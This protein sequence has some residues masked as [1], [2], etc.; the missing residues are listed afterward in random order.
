MELQAPYRPVSILQVRIPLSPSGL[1]RSRRLH[2]LLQ[3]IRLHEHNRRIELKVLVLLLRKSVT[4]ILRFEIPKWSSV[5]L[6]L[7]GHL[8]RL[9]HRHSRIVRPGHHKRRLSNL[10]SVVHRRNAFHELTHLRIALVAILHA[11]QIA[12]IWLRMFEQRDQIAWTNYRQLAAELVFIE[13]SDRPGH[14]TAVAAACDHNVAAIEFRT[15]LDP[16]DQRS[17][18]FVSSL[19]QKSVIKLDEALAITC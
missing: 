18:V 13:R 11:P 5:P 10:R 15:L 9:A 2:R 12:T 14:M 6:Q 8:P 19:T 16:I 1:L 4:F 7:V 3:Q 17:N